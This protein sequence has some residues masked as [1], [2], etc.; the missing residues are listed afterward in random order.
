MK[1]VLLFADV[2]IDDT[3]AMIYSYLSSDIEVVGVV[4]DYGNVPRREQWLRFII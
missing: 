4:A 1:K 2:G 3:I